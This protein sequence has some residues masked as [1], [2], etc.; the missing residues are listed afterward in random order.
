M[1]PELMEQDHEALDDLLQ[2]LQSSLDKQEV[3]TSFELLDLFWARL[4]VHIR[5]ENVR[6]FPAI[7]SA[8]PDV[9]GT[10]LPPLTEVQST[11]KRLRVDHN[12]FM[13]ELSRAMKT[14]RE[15]LARSQSY[16]QPELTAKLSRI[17]DR[18]DAVSNRL[19]AHNELEEEQVYGWPGLILNGS[20]LRILEDAI[21]H[22]IKNLPRRLANPNAL[23]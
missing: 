5:A 19:R 10:T 12:F 1:I 20:R 2:S 8:R 18:V 23:R 6:L 11:L 9:F 3:V 17:R 14:M 4:A 21:K 16:E 7:L 22:E 13:D 15:L